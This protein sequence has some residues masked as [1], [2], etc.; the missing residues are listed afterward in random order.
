MIRSLLVESSGLQHV[1]VG[2][3]EV[4]ARY[5]AVPAEAI[6][7][8]VGSHRLPA[9]CL[10]IICL[11]GGYREYST[12]ESVAFHR[13]GIV[14]RLRLLYP[15]FALALLCVACSDASG[16]VEP[17][18]ESALFSAEERAFVSLVNDHRQRVG[19]EPL[20]WHAEV[21]AV[22]QRHSEDMHARGFFG[23][24]DPDGLSP[25][26][27]LERAGVPFTGWGENV[28][29]GHPTAQRVFEGWLQSP[30]HRASLEN[31]DFTHHGLGLHERYWTHLLVHL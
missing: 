25:A 12:V 24:T 28:A 16:V 30:K 9:P 22:A 21:A 18:T 17:L 7:R 8:Y 19:C 26:D 11:Q 3:G 31:C 29:M 27:R 1:G 13:G 6:L 14:K 15:A 4:R 10:R 20:H 2:W 5:A 23:H